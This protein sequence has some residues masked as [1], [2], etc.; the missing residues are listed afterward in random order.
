MTRDSFH[1]G[2][3]RPLSLYLGAAMTMLAPDASD[4]Q[5]MQHQKA[6]ERMLHGIRKYQNHSWHRD[7]ESLPVVWREGKSTLSFCPAGPGLKSGA[8]LLVPSM[9]NGSEILDLLPC[10]SFV[11]WIS[12]SESGD[13][14]AS[15]LASRS[16]RFF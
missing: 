16:A 13:R 2:A 5:R 10:R 14:S 12:S 6:V 8:L 4:D 7:R 9:I 15:R 11:R 3:P 1:R